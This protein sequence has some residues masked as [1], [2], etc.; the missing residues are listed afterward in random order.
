MR[1]AHR[2]D[3]EHIVARLRQADRN[4]V[5]AATGLPAELVMNG[6]IDVSDRAWTLET[7]E[8]E[9]VALLGTQPI[10][11]YPQFGWVWMVAT[12]EL[13]NHSYEF[14]RRCRSGLSEVYGDYQALTNFVDARNVVH[15]KW[16]R[17]MGFK[18]LRVIPDF[19]AHALPFIEFAGINPKCVDQPS[20]FLGLS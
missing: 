19:G 4:E 15:I 17:F 6:C 12:D 20:P 1:R 14:L 10:Y 3:V 13:V 9:P 16:L 2:E 7:G 11:D 8:G 18:F 5:R